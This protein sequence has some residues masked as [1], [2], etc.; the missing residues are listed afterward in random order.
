MWRRFGHDDL[1]H[2]PHL[3][4]EDRKQI[5]KCDNAGELPVLHDRNAAHAVFVHLREYVEQFIVAVHREHVVGHNVLGGQVL[6][7][8]QKQDTGDPMLA[9][10]LYTISHFKCKNRYAE[11]VSRPGIDPGSVV[12]RRL[13]LDHTGSA[14]DDIVSRVLEG[15]FADSRLRSRS[16]Q[17]VQRVRIDRLIE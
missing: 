3:A 16:E 9:E 11:S 8:L 10:D 1:C 14:Y 17:L 15:H 5:V 7:L 6:E 13:N 4:V 12:V 2:I